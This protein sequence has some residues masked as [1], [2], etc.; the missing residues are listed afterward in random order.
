LE[1]YKIE[2]V[3]KLQSPLLEV[4]L[5]HPFWNNPAQIPENY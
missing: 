4:E 3:K 1:W 5:G 2:I